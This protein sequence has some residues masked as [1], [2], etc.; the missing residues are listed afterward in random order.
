MVRSPDI[1]EFQEIHESLK[2]R[3]QQRNMAVPKAIEKEIIKRIESCKKNDNKPKF[4]FSKMN[5]DDDVVQLIVEI[6][7]DYPIICKLVLSNNPITNK[8]GNFILDVLK[9]Q[10]ID[11]QNIP[12]DRR[13]RS[14]YL[15]HI[16]LN[17]TK[18]DAS[19]LTQIQYYTG[20]L[21]YCNAQSHIRDGYLTRNISDPIP[22]KSIHALWVSL[23]GPPPPKVQDYF[24]KV[25]DQAE[26][27]RVQAV[28]YAQVEK[29]FL[30]CLV[31]NGDLH[32][33]SEKQF[34]ELN[35]QNDV[36]APKISHDNV[37]SA[38]QSDIEAKDDGDIEYPEE[39]ISPMKGDE[40]DAPDKLVTSPAAETTKVEEG[41]TEEVQPYTVQGSPPPGEK[42][43]VLRITSEDEDEEDDPPSES[44]PGPTIVDEL[45]QRN[46]ELESEILRL[47]E[48][49]RELKSRAS[50]EPRVRKESDGS[51]M[52][53]NSSA[54]QDQVHTLK[55]TNQKLKQKL[56]SMR[57]RNDHLLAIINSMEV[58]RA[59]AILAARGGDNT[60]RLLDSVQIADD[61]IVE[62]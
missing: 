20:I 16:E 5:I 2:I 43:R 21:A 6:I 53:P 34:R 17:N 13:L 39:L 51:S 18:I 48:V 7:E 14:I 59:S 9:N 15:S 31:S 19:I 52:P 50:S 3:T 33:L 45:K 55:K 24:H 28:P 44:L 42:S 58:D 29:Q 40:D 23:Y 22:I 30:Q 37:T 25:F 56:E 27:A 4:D 10:L 57:K 26:K 49:I 36:P 8:G 61:D 41:F 46:D 1:S 35:A 38:P 62:F 32:S 12:M 11:I 54:L 60:D 47:H